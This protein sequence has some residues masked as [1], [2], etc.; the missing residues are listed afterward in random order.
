M[1]VRY[2][3]SLGRPFDILSIRTIFSMMPPNR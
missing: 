2:F 3:G 1:A